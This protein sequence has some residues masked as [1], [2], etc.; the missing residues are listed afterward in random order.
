M[1]MTRGQVGSGIRLQGFESKLY[2][3]RQLKAG[4][5]LG[6]VTLGKLFNAS[7]A[8]VFSSV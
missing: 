3:L 1:I 8:S 2:Y 5:E 4:L 6:S 7:E